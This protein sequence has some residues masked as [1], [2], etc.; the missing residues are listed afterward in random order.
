MTFI[1]PSVNTK[2]P[3]RNTLGAL[4]WEAI[5]PYSPNS[6]ISD[7]LSTACVDEHWLRS[8]CF[9]FLRECMKMFIHSLAD[10]FYKTMISNLIRYKVNA[11]PKSYTDYY[12]SLRNSAKFTYFYICHHRIRGFVKMLAKC[13]KKLRSSI[14]TDRQM[15]KAYQGVWN[16]LL[17][18]ANWMGKMDIPPIFQWCV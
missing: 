9:T 12:W 14:K 8:A 7:S 18:F 10:A 6:I 15:L 3:I 17:G 11:M 1:C 16:F 2:E 5:V 13:R 4:N